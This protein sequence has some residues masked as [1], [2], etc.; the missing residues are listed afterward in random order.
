MKS[1]EMREMSFI[2]GISDR[3]GVII[4]DNEFYYL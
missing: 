3:Y 2:K 1:I 4:C